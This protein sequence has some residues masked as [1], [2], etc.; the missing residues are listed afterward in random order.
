MKPT[1]RSVRYCTAA[2]TACKVSVAMHANARRHVRGESHL[3]AASSDRRL[4]S[5]GCTLNNMLL[6]ALTQ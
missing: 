1:N 4:Q 6:I 5:D 3:Q 2:M